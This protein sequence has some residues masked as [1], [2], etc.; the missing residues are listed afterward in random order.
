MIRVVLVGII[1]PQGR[2]VSTSILIC[3]VEPGRELLPMGFRRGRDCSASP[4]ARVFRLLKRFMNGVDDIST[5][6][7][8][9]NVF[10][11]GFYL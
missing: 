9:T 6:L 5:R 11:D 4:F 8:L 10:N 2:A 3:S 7:V 1:S